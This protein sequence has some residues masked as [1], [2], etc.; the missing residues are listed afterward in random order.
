MDIP[1]IILSICLSVLITQFIFYPRYE[2]ISQKIA[3]T[4]RLLENLSPITLRLLYDAEHKFGKGKGALKKSY[5]MDELYQRIPNEYKKFI[6]DRNLSAIIEH[7]LEE[8][9]Y[10]DHLK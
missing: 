8:N 1:A 6:N 4:K 3:I 9:D 2:T 5:V 7:A 10:L